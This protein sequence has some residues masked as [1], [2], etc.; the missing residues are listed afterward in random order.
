MWRSLTG[1]CRNRISRALRNGLSAHDS[2]EPGFA[3]EHYRQLVDVYSDQGLSPPFGVESYRS[4]YRRMKAAGRLLA[5]QVCLDGRCVA[6]GLFPHDDRQVYSVS[7]ASYAAD[8]RL[9]PNEFL[10]WAVMEAAGAKGIVRYNMGDN[11]RRMTG[12]GAF[13]DKFGGELQTVHRYVKSYV[14][15]ARFARTVFRHLVRAREAVGAALR[16]RRR[17]VASEKKDA[18]L[19]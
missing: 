9:C 4:L 8:Q 19:S 13:K 10:H 18:P 1:K 17:A 14:W 2:N 3:D 15:S 11:Y 7:T 6:S 12:S 5:L 16:R